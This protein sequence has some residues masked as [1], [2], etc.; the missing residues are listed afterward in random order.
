MLQA[1]F[2]CAPV[3]EADNYQLFIND[4]IVAAHGYTMQ[5]VKDVIVERLK[6]DQQYL[7][8]WIMRRLPNPPFPNVSRK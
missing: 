7:S 5:E 1:K 2:G 6:Q 4:S 8:W 3:Y